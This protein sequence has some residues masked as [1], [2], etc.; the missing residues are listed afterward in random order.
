VESHQTLARSTRA[1]DGE[2]DLLEFEPM[3]L[4]LQGLYDLQKEENR[5]VGTQYLD[6][7]SFFPALT[8]AFPMYSQSTRPPI[9]RMQ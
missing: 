6:S 5:Q 7:M 9:G 3:W 4:A 2:T 8:V 1:N